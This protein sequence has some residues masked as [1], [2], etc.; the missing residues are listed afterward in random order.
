MECFQ[1]FFLPLFLCVATLE[2]V[3][4]HLKR[5]FPLSNQEEEDNTYFEALVC[6]METVTGNDKEFK[7]GSLEPDVLLDEELIKYHKEHPE[8]S[9]AENAEQM[10]NQL[11]N[12][13]KDKLSCPQ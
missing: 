6:N 1:T 8:R 13:L 5:P 2:K 4:K 7:R 9:L 12:K 3:L 10:L 11:K